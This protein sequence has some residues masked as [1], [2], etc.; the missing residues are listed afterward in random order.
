MKE[1]RFNVGVGITVHN[2]YDVFLKTYNE[3]KKYLPKGSKL[4]IIDDDSAKPVLEATYRFEQNVG[5]A[6]A[7]N[8]CIELLEDC[9]NIFLFDDDTYPI[10]SD[11]WKP[12]VESKEPHLMYLFQDFAKNPRLNDCV[13]LYNDGIIKAYSHPRGC[14]LYLHNSVIKS[15]GG[16]N[17]N[18][19]KWGN[20]H[21]DLSNRI[22]NKGL[23]SFR[24]A[25]VVGSE[26][27][28]HSGDEH[29][30]VQTTV[31]ALERQKCLAASNNLL[32]Q[33][34]E[35]TEYIDYHQY[36]N[37][38]TGQR[39]VIL[40]CYFNN[41]IDTQRGIVWSD[42][43]KECDALINSC[44]DIELIIFT[45]IKDAK[46]P[47]KTVPSDINPYFQRWLSYYQFLRDNPDIDNVFCVDAT[48]VELNINPFNYID[49]NKIYCGDEESVLGSRWILN[50][51]ST[52]INYISANRTKRLLNAGVVG[53]SRE[54][55][56]QISHD[57]IREYFDSKNQ[58][59]N[60]MP[61]FNKVLYSKYGD[62]IKYG[63]EVTNRFKSFDKTGR[64]WFFHK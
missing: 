10:S 22:F 41:Q 3:F 44:K 7:K 5:I 1:E 58:L 64:S 35:S 45:N 13:Q 21:V 25:D 57:I 63:R 38:T 16:M 55:I 52:L 34:F 50:Y 29:E 15:V 6:A 23:T 4:I 33:S 40:S 24:Y 19:G 61:A 54:N 59:P 37:D 26:N 39:N 20:E 9:E 2:R 43:L 48:D 11:W 30:E 36:L 27:L 31:G 62:K 53:G 32:R 12:Y 28:I 49:Q 60:D 47:F 14:M 42:N 17:I 18:Y 8:K 51:S 56:M 46:Y